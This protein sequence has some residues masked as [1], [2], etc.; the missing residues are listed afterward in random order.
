MPPFVDHYGGRRPRRE[1]QYFEWHW[2][3]IYILMFMSGPYIAYTAYSILQIQQTGLQPLLH[4]R[5]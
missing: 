5:P 3:I 1:P 4:L 2:L